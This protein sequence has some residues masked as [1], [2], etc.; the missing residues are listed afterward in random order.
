MSLQAGA[1]HASLQVV[2]PQ[3]SL[4]NGNVEQCISKRVEENLDFFD[5]ALMHSLRADSSLNAGCFSKCFSPLQQNSGLVL[6]RGISF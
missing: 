5:Q 6:S 3:H 4:S 1:G 2:H